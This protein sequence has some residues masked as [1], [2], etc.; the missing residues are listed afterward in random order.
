MHDSVGWEHKRE[1][2]DGLEA[3]MAGNTVL[4]LPKSL[5]YKYVQHEMY[6]ALH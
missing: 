2:E 5:V 4:V 6:S 1:R 3:N